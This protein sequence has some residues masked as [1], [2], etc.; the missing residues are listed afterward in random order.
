[1]IAVVSRFIERSERHL[2]RLVRDLVRVPTVN[3]P[4]EHYREMIELLQ[5]RCARL[6]FRV[7]VHRVPDAL[8]RQ[9]AGTADF[10]RYNLVARWDVGAE[11]TVHFNAHYDVVPAAG[12]WRSGGPFR[13]GISRGWCYGRGSGDMK[14]SIAALLT[15]VEALQRTGCRPAFNIECSFTADEETGGELGAGYLVRQ[16]LV[17]ADGVVVCEG[18]SGTQVGCGHNG[19]LWLEVEIRGRAAHASRPE[20]GIN[21][22]EQMVDLV[23]GLDP[24]KRRLADPRRRY[25]DFDGQQ[26][27]PTVNLG[28]VFGGGPGDKINTV[29]ARASF[30]IDRRLLPGEA[31]ERAEDELR[32]A[33]QR[34]ASRHAV[35]CEIRS[36]LRLSPCV[37]DPQHPLLRAFARAVRTSRRQA[38]GFRVSSGFTDLHYFVEEGGL[39]GLGYGVKG[40]RAHG[41]DERVEVR[42][43]L[44]T[45]RTYAGFMLRRIETG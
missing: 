39:P 20:E 3:P 27:S 18:G 4:G 35:R 2:I 25:R 21:A 9:V 38:A 19:V 10:P 45:A 12:R 28:G 1:M 24:V 16:G 15:A 6:G 31:L 7:G 11:R 23:R 44:Q 14:G 32:Q 43:L 26:R 34:A 33:L 42:D 13:P 8:V 40:A 29:P 36:L 30:T 17:K 41:Q 5:E 22:F 37:V